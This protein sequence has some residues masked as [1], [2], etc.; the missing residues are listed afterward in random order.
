M[1]TEPPRP[2]FAALLRG[3]LLVCGVS[4]IL[5]LVVWLLFRRFE[6]RP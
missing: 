1:T 6:I 3:S 4:L 2:G 5:V